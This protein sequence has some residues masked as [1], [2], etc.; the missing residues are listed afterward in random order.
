[1]YE[2]MGYEEKDE[3]MKFGDVEEIINEEEGDI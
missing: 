1:M 3:V 2:M